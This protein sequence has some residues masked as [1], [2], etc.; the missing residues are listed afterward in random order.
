[1]SNMKAFRIFFVFLLVTFAFSCEN[2]VLGPNRVSLVN[3]SECY[4]DEP[5]N[6]YVSIILRNPYELGMTGGVITVDIYEG[7]L[8]DNI[9]F[10]SIQA[11]RTEVEVN[12]PVNKK[13]TF[14]AGYFIDNKTYVVVNSIRPKVKYDKNSCD[15]PCYYTTPRKVNLKL[16]YTK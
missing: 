16:R 11:T 2:D 9:I 10:K 5:L 7:N 12:L 6:A 8:E 3:C 14:T 1:M 4:A 13:Y 15:E